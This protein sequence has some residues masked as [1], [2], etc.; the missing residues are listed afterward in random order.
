M[1]LV[2]P[3]RVLAVDGAVAEVELHGGLVASV[4]LALLPDVQVGQYVMV[5]RGL[6]LEVIPPDEVAALLA[7][8][9]E[10]GQALAEPVLP[11]AVAGRADGGAL[12]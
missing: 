12:A 1:C 6:V 8:Y 7:L 11:G 3:A 4:S 9:D 5:D 2:L 10:L